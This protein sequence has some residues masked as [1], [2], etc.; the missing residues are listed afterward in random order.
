[1]ARAAHQALL[2]LRVERAPALAVLAE[3]LLLVGIQRFPGERRG[4]ARGRFVGAGARRHGDVQPGG[5]DRG[6]RGTTRDDRTTPAADPWRAAAACC[7]A[8]PVSRCPYSR[9]SPRNPR[10]ACPRSPRRCRPGIRADPRRAP[11][12]VQASERDRSRLHFLAGGPFVE[13]DVL[14]VIGE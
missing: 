11:P 6:Q 7:R 14:A 12:W 13:L 9:G 4:R 8:A 1:A 3:H 5:D 2:L 10:P